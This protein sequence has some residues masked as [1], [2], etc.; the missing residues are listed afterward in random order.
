MM[1]K[2][3]QEKDFF[4]LLNLFPEIFPEKIKTESLLYRM[5]GGRKRREKIL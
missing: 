5:P 3:R 1:Q 2:T 4:F